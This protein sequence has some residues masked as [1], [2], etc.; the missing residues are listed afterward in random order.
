ML[1]FFVYIVD[2]FEVCN[3]YATDDSDLAYDI[4]ISFAAF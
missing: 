1:L 3:Y 2:A 4:S